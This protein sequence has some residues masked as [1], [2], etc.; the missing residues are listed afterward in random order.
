M[1]DKLSVTLVD[2]YG[3][4]TTRVYGMESEALLATYLTNIGAFLTALEAVTD[5]GCLKASLILPITSPEWSAIADANKDTGGTASGWI[6]AGS[7]KRA[8]LKIPGVKPTLVGADGTI[9]ITGVVATFLAEFEDAANF[10]LSDG[11]QID[12]WIKA[13]LDG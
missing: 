2:D 10:N 4:T 3:R 8:S 9:A 5:L 11:E 12:A 6:N 1:V 13:T 7:G